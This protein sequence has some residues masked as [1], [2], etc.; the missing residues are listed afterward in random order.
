MYKKCLT[1]IDTSIILLIAYNEAS[2]DNFIEATMG[3]EVVVLSSVIDELN[4]LKDLQD[5]RSKKALWALNNIVNNFTVVHIDSTGNVDQDLINFAL[6]KIKEFKVF[7]AT[8]DSDLK[9]KALL[10]GIGVIFYRKS[11]NKFEVIP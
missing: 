5:N 9:N 8:V 2:L 1:L 3:C 11:K 6:N 7:I 10:K 4:R